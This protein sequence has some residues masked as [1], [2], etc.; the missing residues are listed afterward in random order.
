MAAENY[1]A[2]EASVREYAKL[3]PSSGFGVHY[4]IAGLPIEMSPRRRSLKRNTNP[5]FRLQPLAAVYHDL[6][7][8]AESDAALRELT[9]KHARDAAFRIAEVYACRH[10]ADEA[11]RGLPAQV[12]FAHSSRMTGSSQ[13]PTR[14]CV[15]SYT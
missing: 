8:K 5:V 12:E 7:R 11:I 15:P 1:A 13:R 14:M 9:E 6:H 10:E 3:V 4:A 2:A